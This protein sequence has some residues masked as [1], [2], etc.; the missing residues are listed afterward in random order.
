MKKQHQ[1]WKISEIVKLSNKIEFP[2]FQR[3]APIWKLEKKQRL[4]D[5]I[6]R[7]F[8]ISSIYLFQ[9]ENDK[10]DCIDGQQR[11]NAIW[12]YIGINDSD[13]DNKFHLKISN[14]IYN[15]GNRFKEVDQK[16]YEFLEKKWQNNI[17]NY[18]LNIVLLSNI[19][20]DEELNLQFLRLQLGAALNA[21][22]RLNAMTGDMRDAIFNDF[23]NHAFFNKIKIQSRRFAREQIAAQI[24]LNSF[25]KKEI[26]EF[27]RSRYTD[28]QDFFK[29]KE[30]FTKED[31]KILKEIEATLSLVEKKFGNNLKYISNRALAV[32]VYLFIT[33][34]IEQK[35]D[36]EI[37]LFADFFIEFLKTL[38]WQIPR[39]FDMDKE[40]RELLNF[41]T[42]ISQAAGE[43]TAIQKRHDFLKEYFYYYKKNKNIKGDEE[44]K[45]AKRSDPD[46][47]REKIKL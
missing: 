29:S 36:N 38:K 9:K 13:E 1:R 46:K 2:E 14:E 37:S 32:S 3:E 27:H 41:Q 34:L 25:S 44:Y 11:I 39:G 22:E 15:D 21:G 43:K 33:D 20:E 40:Y 19:E 24:I 10:Y 8:D 6:L 16:R 17:I 4:I 18:E 47:Q 45:K 28:L 31:S 42:N 30:K 23:K 7:D 12:S 26:G 35:K 5:S